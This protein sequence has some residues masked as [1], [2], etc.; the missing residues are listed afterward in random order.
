MG[1]SE[2]VRY[3]SKYG[4]DR[5]P[6]AGFI[7]STITL[8]AQKPDNPSGVPQQILNQIM[9]VLT[10]DRSGFLKDFHKKFYY[11]IQN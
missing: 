6:K 8:I 3:I 5:I 9:V 1:F 2:V 11:F 10:K 7:A 4:E